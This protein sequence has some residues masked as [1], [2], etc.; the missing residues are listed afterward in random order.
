MLDTS[1]MSVAEMLATL[2]GPQ[3][4]TALSAAA[5]LLPE[6]IIEAILHSWDNILKLS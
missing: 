4:L 1:N 3:T 5:G 2:D 6:P